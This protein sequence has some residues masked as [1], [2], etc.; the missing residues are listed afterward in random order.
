M[1]SWTVL[2]PPSLPAFAQKLPYVVLLVELDEGVR[3]IGFLVDT[4]GKWLRSDGEAEGIHMGTRVA[5]RFYDQ[6][7]TSLPSW[8]VAS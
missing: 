3:L 2:R 8:T 4:E 6:A 7:G 1:A 5:L